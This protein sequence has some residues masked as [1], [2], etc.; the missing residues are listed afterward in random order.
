MCLRGQKNFQNF[1][2]NTYKVLILLVHLLKKKKNPMEEPFHETCMRILQSIQICWNL[3]KWE[4]SPSRNLYL[5]A[6]HL[7]IFLIYTQLTWVLQVLEVLG[8]NLQNHIT[9]W[10]PT[11]MISEFEA[12]NMNMLV[13]ARW[14]VGVAAPARPIVSD[15]CHYIMWIVALWNFTGPLCLFFCKTKKKSSCDKQMMCRNGKKKHFHLNYNTS[16]QQ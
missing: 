1:S 5:F 3:N 8:L 9:S 10:L 14:A 12:D 15:V 13:G 11:A 6:Q 16:T 7:F 4:T 2:T